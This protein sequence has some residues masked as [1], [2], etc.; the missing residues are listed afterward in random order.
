MG[1]E[2]YPSVELKAAAL[3]HSL[4]CNHALVDGNKR[5]AAILSLVFLEI[6]DASYDLTNDELFELTMAVASGRMRD[7]SEIA[8]GL[9]VVQRE[10]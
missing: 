8:E 1:D 4:V 2:A 5:L 9:H 7:V 6:N 3:F 10:H